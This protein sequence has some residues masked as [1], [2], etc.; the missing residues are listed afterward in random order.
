M[1]FSFLIP[2]KNRLELLKL[3]VDSVRR[4]EGADFEI[5][6]ADNASSEDYRGLVAQLNDARIVYERAE[7]PVSVTE[8]W[9]R[10]LRLATGDYILML[11]D[12]DALAPGYLAQML[13]LIQEHQQPDII[14]TA[15]YHYCY[16]NVIPGRPAGYLAD[17]RNSVFFKDRTKP[18]LLPLE[19]ARRAARAVGDFRYLFGFNSQHFLFRAGFL[20]SLSTKDDIRSDSGALKRNPGIPSIFQ[21]PYP[22]TFAAMVSFLY[23]QSVVVVPT[24]MII[25]GISPK[26]FGYY[27]FN[28][29]QN[30]GYKFL[31]NEEVAAEVRDSVK[32]HFLPGDGNNT[33]WL[34][35]VETARRMLPPELGLTVNIERYRRLQMLAFLRAVYQKKVRP[36]DEIEPFTA[37]LTATE[38][39]EFD[40]MQAEIEKVAPDDP[41]QLGRLFSFWDR[42]LEQF[43]PAEI[44]MMPIVS[45]ANV[46][47]VLCWLERT[48]PVCPCC[49]GAARLRFASKDRNQ[50]TAED[51]YRYYLC[52][53]CALTYLE[54]IPK[55]LARVYAKEQFSIPAPDRNA[56]QAQAETQKWKLEILKSLVSSGTLFEVG[57]ATGE[58]AYLAKQAGF[59]PKLAEMN[60]HCCQFLRE[61]LDLN[62]TQTANPVAAL[63][64]EKKF[65]AICIWQ[66]IEH[67]PSFWQL[68][69]ETAS[70]LEAGGVLIVST[71]NPFSLQARILGRYW[72]HIDAPRHLYLIPQEWFREFA[73]KHKLKV[74]L[75]TTRDEGSL[76]LNYYGW[77]LAVRNALQRKLSDR[78]IHRLARPIA[79]VLRKWEESEGKGCSYTIA[80]RKE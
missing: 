1:K 35:A 76:G 4:Q 43:C 34:V 80:F 48:P 26:S 29:L 64:A 51:E 40:A 17:V 52:S 57:P 77:Y 32:K 39:K 62:V 68:M 22:D 47:D 78:Y 72:P 12:D 18:F 55:D 20:Q 6:I 45:H 7:Q 2:S 30:E 38:R 37:L 79:R 44:S 14:F 33:H 53:Q 31:D 58:F 25:I 46:G 28:D 19:E 67:V 9:N 42:Q 73:R 41:D 69:D 36:K 8:N 66:T 23:A 3:A 21:S 16:P 70:H 10:A 5:I 63:A 75:D 11:G 49:G 50:H 54:N 27:Y 13:R 71:P 74:V 61:V 65:D 56:F 24:P 60:S 59:Q 15:A